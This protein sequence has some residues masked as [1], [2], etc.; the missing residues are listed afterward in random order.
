MAARRRYEASY[1]VISS[2][3]GCSE[4]MVKR[5]AQAGVDVSNRSELLAFIQQHGRE[6]SRFAV[7]EHQ[8][9]A[10]SQKP[11]PLAEMPRK[12]KRKWLTDP[13]NKNK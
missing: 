10:V 12:P 1:L 8:R 11:A 4:S 5:A 9:A 13:F 6:K 7:A 3:I 2:L